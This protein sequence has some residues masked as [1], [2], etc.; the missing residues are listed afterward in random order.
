M[1]PAMDDEFH[2]ADV[3][4]GQPLKYLGFAVGSIGVAALLMIGWPKMSFFYHAITVV[5]VPVFILITVR[6]ITNLLRWRQPMLAIGPRGIFD[7]RVSQT[8]IPWVDVTK[9]VLL[10][11]SDEAQ[12]LRI[13]VSPDFATHFPQ[14]LLSRIQRWSN[15]LAGLQGYTIAFGGLDADPD[16]VARVLDRH[17]PQWRRSPP[18]GGR[19]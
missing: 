5:S 14:K 6:F 1:V 3:W 9:I 17:F 15:S 13:H 18:S 19:S 7:W 10:Q 2:D 4:P 16:A 11:K 8:W 12:G